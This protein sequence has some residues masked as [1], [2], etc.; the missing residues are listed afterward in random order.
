MATRHWNAEQR[1]RAEAGCCIEC[2]SP[3]PGGRSY[4]CHDCQGKRTMEDI[5]EEIAVLRRNILKTP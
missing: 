4:L 1:R 3:N 5:R 2:G